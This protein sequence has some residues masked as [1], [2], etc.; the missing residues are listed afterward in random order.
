MTDT[1]KKDP[2]MRPIMT[3]AELGTHEL[4]QHGR[5][6]RLSDNGYSDMEV[7]SKQGWEEVSGWGLDGWD[8]GSW[9]YVV[10]SVRNVGNLHCDPQYQYQMRQT[11]EGDTTVYGFANDADRAAAID[12]LFIWYGVGKDYEEWTIEG[13]SCDKREALDAGTLRVPERFRG[14]FSWAR[15]NASKVA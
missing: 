11:I 2:T 6:Y 14:A 4:A 7:A 15:L 3:A 12:Y 9:P 5:D 1:K 8:L 13:L 10:V